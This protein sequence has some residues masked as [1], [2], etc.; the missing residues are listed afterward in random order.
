MAFPVPDH[1]PRR[2]IPQDVSSKILNRI[3]AAT[4]QTLNAELARTW[5]AMLDEDVRSTKQRIRDR[6]Q[7]ELPRFES[8]L[9]S[10]K[11]ARRQLHTLERDVDGLHE[12]VLNS[13]TGLI[14]KITRRLGKHT[15]LAQE[16]TN[17]GVCYQALLHL[18]NC[19]HEYT[20]LNALVQ[21]GELTEAVQAS[22]QL[23]TLL[24]SAPTALVQA[25][26]MSDFKRKSRV[27]EFFIQ[28]Q[29]SEAYSRSVVLSYNELSIC[30]SVQVR[31]AETMISLPAILSV[32]SN[33]S[34]NGHL[35]TFRRDLAVN[36]VDHV[37]TNPCS[38]AVETDITRSGKL[39][40][41]PLPPNNE[42]LTTRFTNLSAILDFLNVHL[43]PHIP[44]SHW[45]SFSHSLCKLL[46]SS[47]LDHLLRS[48]LP[49]TVEQLPSYLSI[50]QQ[51][52]EFEQKYILRMLDGDSND[53]PIQSWADNLGG[54]YERKRRIQILDLSKSVI[55]APG[56]ESDYFL[57]ETTLAPEVAELL[58]PPV[59]D[60]A[61]DTA[62]T[63]GSSED[64]WGFE[65]DKK[66][67]NS[68]STAI[69]ENSWG[70][71]DDS[72][73]PEIQSGQH[74]AE[75]LTQTSEDVLDPGDAWEWNDGNVDDSGDDSAWDDPWAETSGSGKGIPKASVQPAQQIKAA[76][77][78]E[79]LAAKNKKRTNV[80][81]QSSS[82]PNLPPSSSSQTSPKLPGVTSQPFKTT[83]NEV[84]KQTSYVKSNVIKESHRVSERMRRLVK[85]VEDV[86]IEGRNLSKSNVLPPPSS[87][88]PLGTIILQ[89]S[90]SILDL[91][92]GLYPAKHAKELE[93]ADRAM[94]F[95]NDCLYLS[96]RIERIMNGPAHDHPSLK[97]RFEECKLYF[98][99][100]SDSWYD[101]TID[102]QQQKLDRLLAEG[103][104]GFIDSSG[105]DR[106]DE[107]EDAVNQALKEIRSLAHK[108]KGLLPKSKY[109]SALGL[110]TEAALSRMLEDILALPDIPEVESHRLSEL[111]RIL[112]ALE[113]LF[114]EDINQ[115]SFVL[116]Y[117]PSWL[118]FSYLSELLEASMA[119][120][121]YLFET[122]ALVDFG[123]DELVR[124][125]QALF[126]DTTLRTNTINKISAGH[127][128]ATEH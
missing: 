55:I 98:Q 74:P 93:E 88:S 56:G 57:E 54:H 114:M 119:D 47:I 28:E 106:Y 9:E 83:E 52:I 95:S 4:N 49:S 65:D 39:T 87:S 108:W 69:D 58:T 116:A 105:Q 103:T 123:V 84:S 24:S 20:N 11:S 13:E 124:L 33:E 122:G 117:V 78:L 68:G 26:I 101:D 100:L 25:K 91:F 126:A 38:V 109:Y 115:P 112:S 75:E 35:S 107:C 72:M 97:E 73:E 104:Q 94:A 120:I 82:S 66:S 110:V 64:A 89:T 15:T 113:G 23:N 1:L 92:R 8:L 70:F 22:R 30:S 53:R 76:S 111:C 16:A 118:K 41:I 50:T 127:P 60:Q 17:T 86:V 51:A 42:N 43:F 31:K 40:C 14:S 44:A 90:S 99:V 19:Q 10:A 37:L 12:T 2:A 62:P 79:K 128:I 67:R 48:F 5:L 7:A 34:L 36:F 61:E 3:D 125:V 96:D 121:T 80:D 102:K 85:I 77:R 27:A 71:D 45:S 81:V 29:L 18:A 63:E 32:L 6:I 59:Q 46:S 21:S